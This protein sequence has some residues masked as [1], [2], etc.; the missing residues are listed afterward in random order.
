MELKLEPDEKAIFDEIAQN[1]TLTRGNLAQRRT[2]LV[3]ELNKIDIAMAATE[4]QG[5]GALRAII[6]RRKLEGDWL[7]DSDKGILCQIGKTGQVPRAPASAPD[8][9]AAPASTNT[10]ASPISGGSK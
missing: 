9:P 3:E 6:R 7:V 8:T 2:I 4:G 1:I 5:N 10:E